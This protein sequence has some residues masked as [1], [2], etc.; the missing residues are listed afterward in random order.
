M[1]GQD[2][3]LIYG[4]AKSIQRQ[5]T[6][7]ALGTDIAGLGGDAKYFRARLENTYHY[8]IATNWVIHPLEKLAI[9]STL[10]KTFE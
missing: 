5:G 1:I 3:T 2:L 7:L 9:W 8:Q 6:Y 10:A 4:T